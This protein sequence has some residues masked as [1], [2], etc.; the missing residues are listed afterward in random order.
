MKKAIVIGSGAGG[1]TAAK[2]LQR[3]FQVTVLEAGG[4]FQ[5]FNKNLTVIEKI[6]KSGVFFNEHLI[7]PIFPAM[8]I[9]KTVGK[10]VLVNGIGYGGTTTISAGNA[11]RCDKGLIALGID[12]DAEFAEIYQEIPVSSA[13]QK[14]WH[15]P[16]KQV[17][18]VCQDM[19]LQPLPTPKMVYPGRC[20][21][22]GRCV[23]GC[24]R[25]AKWDIRVFLKQAVEKGYHHVT[26]SHLQKV[27]ME[28]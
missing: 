3:K 16:T 23:L 22:C 25:G 18:G 28:K 4:P 11:V 14:T 6:K 2:E 12:L 1:A 9:R 7:Q 24:S 17:F 13:H 8:R 26:K 5:P 19:E 15:N 10:M 27:E 21:G 20:T